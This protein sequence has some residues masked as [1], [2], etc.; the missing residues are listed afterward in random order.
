MKKLLFRALLVLAALGV[1]LAAVP[2][3]PDCGPCDPPPV[4]ALMP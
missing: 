1:P 4:V 3:P 2:P